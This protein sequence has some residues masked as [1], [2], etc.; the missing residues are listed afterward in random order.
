MYSAEITTSSQV[1]ATTSSVEDFA[2]RSSVANVDCEQT[3][4][5]EVSVALPAAAQDAKCSAAWV[6]ATGATKLASHCRIEG[7]IAHAVGQITA[8]AKVCSPDKLCTCS[9]PAQAWLE[10]RGAYRQPTTTTQLQVDAEPMQ[11]TFPAGG[12]AEMRVGAREGRKLR[13]VALAISR[14]ACATVLDTIDLV[15]GDDPNG[16]AAAPSASGEFRAAIKAG[17]LKV[18]ASEAFAKDARNGP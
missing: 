12:V 5:V 4:T 17:A 18:G 10:A 8:G 14:R 2:E 15:I 13:D 16:E 7:Q 3:K 11:T 6:D 9:V 1:S